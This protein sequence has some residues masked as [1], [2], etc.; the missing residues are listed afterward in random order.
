MALKRGKKV[1]ADERKREEHRGTVQLA[2]R[3][4]VGYYERKGIEAMSL[5]VRMLLT[6]PIKRAP[7]YFKGQLNKYRLRRQASSRIK[8]LPMI[9]YLVTDSN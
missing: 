9:C 1:S 4:K 3:R 2:P 7:S 6:L 5:F 8:S